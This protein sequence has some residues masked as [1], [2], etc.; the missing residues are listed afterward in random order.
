MAIKKEKVG[1]ISYDAGRE[2]IEW[3]ERFF[4]ISVGSFDSWKRNN[5]M[6]LDITK[7][8]PTTSNAIN[9]DSTPLM[10]IRIANQISTPLVQ[11]YENTWYCVLFKK[12]APSTRPKIGNVIQA[13]IS[14]VA[15]ILCGE[16]IVH[17]L[18]SIFIISSCTC[19][20][21]K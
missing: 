20:R 15:P 9:H 10:P 13:A 21:K 7:R 1:R 17:C 8:Q 2:S 3:I 14:L 19:R 6:R 4:F 18:A 12:I 16:P 5:M 11:L